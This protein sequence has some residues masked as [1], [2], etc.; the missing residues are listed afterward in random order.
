MT[1]N[2]IYGIWLQQALG[3]GNRKASEL[4]SYFGSCKNVFEADDVELKLSGLVRMEDIDRLLSTSIDTAEE[5]ME[6]CNRLGYRII[7][8]DDD[9]YPD[10]LRNI[11]D[12]PVALYYTG[13]WPDVDNE[14]IIAMVGTRIASRYGYSMAT[15]ISKN[16]AACGAIVISGCARGID[17]ASHQGAIMAGGKTL[18]V[19]GCGIN[20]N[21]N[22]AN[23]GLRKVIETSGALITEYPPGTPPLGYHFP[24]RNRIISAMSLGV[25]VVEAGEKSGSLITATLALDQGKDIFAVPG[26]IGHPSSEGTNRLISQGAKPVGSAY[27]VLEEYT[28]LFPHRLRSVNLF[29]RNP[30]VQETHA[31]PKWARLPKSVS[32]PE[33]YAPGK[34]RKTSSQKPPAP[35]PEPTPESESESYN[36]PIGMS[37]P[38][39]RLR[40][41]LGSAPKR[42][43]D[44]LTELDME[45]SEL[46]RCITELELYGVIKSLPGN[47]YCRN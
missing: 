5:I 38:A 25:I 42:F 39:Q 3:E 37:K 47:K 12:F 9:N 43:G 26:E 21:Y 7:T 41:A 20:T 17:T 19:L 45:P 14:V 18:G 11:P 35:E 10:R 1:E 34:Q 28:T 8:S 2:S 4:V 33:T 27:D 30:I 46:S 32:P 15:D 6:S 22:M 13:E 23:E 36:P 40:N 24:V 44:L 29:N 16:L 31:R